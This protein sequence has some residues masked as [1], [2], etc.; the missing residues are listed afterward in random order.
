MVKQDVNLALYTRVIFQSV[1]VKIIMFQH[2]P[3]ESGTAKQYGNIS[4]YKN[5]ALKDDKALE[6]LYK[7]H[8]IFEI[9]IFLNYDYLVFFVYF[10]KIKINVAKIS[11]ILSFR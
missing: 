9:Y 3:F 6:V 1:L 5:G 4:F 8:L 7:K 11:L 10:I 2:I